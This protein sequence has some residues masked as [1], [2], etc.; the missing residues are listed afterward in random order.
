M[1][2]L[3]RASIVALTSALL[4]IPAADARSSGRARSGRSSSQSSSSRVRVR[5][6]QTK[7]GKQVQSH[8]RSTRNRSKADN[9]STKGNVN[10]VTGKA[11]TKT[12]K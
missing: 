8:Q 2:T 5:S 9:W 4:M 3:R 10:P 11:G 12:P 6:Y 7:S 1:R